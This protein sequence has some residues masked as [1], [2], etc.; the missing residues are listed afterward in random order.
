MS[1]APPPV[2]N[3]YVALLHVRPRLAAKMRRFG[4]FDEPSRLRL[5]DDLGQLGG[6]SAA[7]AAGG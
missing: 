5:I 7:G 3:E 4:L 2:A 6:P 1:S